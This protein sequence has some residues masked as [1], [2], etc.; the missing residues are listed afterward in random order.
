VIVFT[1][2]LTGPQPGDWR[3]IGIYP[4]ARNTTRFSYC[5]I[6]YAGGRSG[7]G[8]F[9]VEG[10]A[11]RVDYCSISQGGDYGVVATRD[12]RFS[13]FSGN[14][15]TACAGYPVVIQ[16]QSVSTLGA[17]NVLT[18]NSQDGVFVSGG[19]VSLSGTWL[20]QD[21]PY[22]IGSDIAIGGPAGPVLTI[23]PGTRL[24]FTPGVEFYVGYAE[25]GG[26]IADGTTGRIEFTSS[27]ALPS[28]GDWVGLAFYAQSMSSQC[29]LINCKVEYGGGSDDGNI[30]IH[31]CTPEVRGDSIG[32]SSAWGIYLQGTVYPDPDLLRANNTFYDCQ[33][34]DIHDPGAWVAE[35]IRPDGWVARANPTIVRGC[36]WLPQ[37]PVASGRSPSALLDISGRKVTVLRPG[38]NDVS[39]LAPGVYF[40]RSGLSAV[41]REPSAVGSQR[42][43]IQH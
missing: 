19:D 14:T 10:A 5:D 21:V 17:G 15:V 9:S 24:T 22:V 8:S 7:D 13:L 35:A 25:P 16:A 27:A 2:N 33:Y 41:S 39:R 43:V 38:A 37:S 4:F 31:D 12:G 28:P 18:G 42:V 20:N 23:A 1:S 3:G 30:L 29:K 6:S 40:V 32:H 26:L 11:C 36:L 34:G